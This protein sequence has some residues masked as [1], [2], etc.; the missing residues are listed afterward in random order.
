MIACVAMHA[1]LMPLYIFVDGLTY[2]LH[3]KLFFEED[4]M[5]FKCPMRQEM[6]EL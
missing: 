1:H 5:Q 3:N 2:I 4:S 6:W